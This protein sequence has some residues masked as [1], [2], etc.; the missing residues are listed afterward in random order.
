[1]TVND[2]G[3]QV[4]N[5]IFGGGFIAVIILTSLGCGR[6]LGGGGDG[7]GAVVVLRKH[8]AADR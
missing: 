1:M 8:S 7:G 6:F 2:G 4:L 3:R 5:S